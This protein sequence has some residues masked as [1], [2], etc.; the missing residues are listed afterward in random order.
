MYQGYTKRWRKLWDSDLANHPNASHLF[1][2]LID[3]AAWKETETGYRYQ[4]VILKRG[5][6]LIGRESL[7]KKIG[8]T[9]RMIRTNLNYLKTTNRIT[10]KTTNRFSV[11][12]IINYDIYQSNEDNNDQQND[13]QSD[14]QATSKRPASDHIEE[15]KELKELKPV[16]VSRPKR[17]RKAITYTDEFE[18]FWSRYPRGVGKGE[19]F[20]EWQ[21]VIIDG[22]PAEK[23]IKAAGEYADQVRREGRDDSKIRHACRFLKK[24]FWKDYCFKEKG[25]A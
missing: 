17:T 9:S 23:V 13:Q 7:S 15:L 25:I 14:Q 24:D 2:Y 20:I 5:E 11:I 4:C 18:S 3:H 16:C 1:A 12:S 8:L 19:A 6:V 10:I 22:Y 21:K